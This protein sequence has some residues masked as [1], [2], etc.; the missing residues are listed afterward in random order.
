M[1]IFDYEYSDELA[2]DDLAEACKIVGFHIDDVFN[3]KVESVVIDVPQAQAL[4]LV[5]S[6]EDQSVEFWRRRKNEFTP[7]RR[8]R[9]MKLRAEFQEDLFVRLCSKFLEATREMIARGMFGVWDDQY[10][11][12][13][14]DKPEP[15]PF[16][17]DA[18]RASLLPSDA[19]IVFTIWPVERS[20]TWFRLRSEHYQHE[21]MVSKE[22]AQEKS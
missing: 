17:I 21:I 18:I 6:V 15:K 2:L 19:Q 8:A 13:D 1:E 16:S 12:N 11:P 10:D 3:D 5:L 4:S 14:K 20:L 7:M 22:N 9:G